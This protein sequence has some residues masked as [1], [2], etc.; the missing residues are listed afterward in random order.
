[1]LIKSQL[2]VSIPD[3]ILNSVVF[4]LDSFFETFKVPVY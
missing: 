1:M 4:I 3:G 2:S